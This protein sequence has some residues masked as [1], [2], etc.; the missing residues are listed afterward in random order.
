MKAQPLKYMYKK[1]EKTWTRKKDR[2]FVELGCFFAEKGE[3]SCKSS[4]HRSNENKVEK[5]VSFRAQKK[6]IFFPCGDDFVIQADK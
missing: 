5:Y 1:T 4:P 6:N 3:K 2:K